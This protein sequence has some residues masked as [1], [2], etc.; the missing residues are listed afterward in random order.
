MC[1]KFSGCHDARY[2]SGGSAS[3]S[4]ATVSTPASRN[5]AGYSC[6]V[7]S[8]STTTA[9]R[10]MVLLAVRAGRGRAG[11]GRAASGSD[12]PRGL[13]R[14]ERILA[15]ANR[16]GHSCS[17][18]DPAQEG[19]LW[20]RRCDIPGPGHGRGPVYRS[21]QRCVIEVDR[22]DN[23]VL[24][25]DIEEAHR[26]RKSE[27]SGYLRPLAARHRGRHQSRIDTRH[28]HPQVRNAVAAEARAHLDDL[29]ARDGE[30]ELRVRH[31]VGE[32][33]RGVRVLDD[34]QD[35]RVGQQR[36]GAVHHVADLLE[37]WRVANFLAGYEHRDRLAALHCRVDTY[38]GT[39]EIFLDQHA[40]VV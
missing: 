36:V 40:D 23:G 28:A 9:Y 26:A 3:E 35:L 20:R 31:T 34:S 33:Q 4:T 7:P 6:P 24:L 27:F 21:G 13:R 16:L 8:G 37:I 14:I 10:C 32:P 12:G 29:R 5:A 19:S 11:R 17:E 39:G 15:F 1:R 30:L 38:L 18:G 22:L 25:L 2:I